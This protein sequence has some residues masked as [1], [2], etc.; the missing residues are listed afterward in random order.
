MMKLLTAKGLI[1][2]WIELILNALKERLLF[3]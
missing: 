3:I 1:F 2:L